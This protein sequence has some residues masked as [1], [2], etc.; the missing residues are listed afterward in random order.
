MATNSGLR[1][2]VIKSF[3]IDNSYECVTGGSRYDNPGECN[4]W[5]IDGFVVLA[6]GSK[7]R[8]TETWQD[9]VAPF[10]FDELGFCLCESFANYI[11]VLR[12]GEK[13]PHW[14]QEEIDNP[15][16]LAARTEAADG[17]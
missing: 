10:V 2:A 12:V 16:R 1:G 3:V 14:M 7:I 5:R 4:R 11:G 9:E 13:I 6:R 15:T 8:T 17:Q